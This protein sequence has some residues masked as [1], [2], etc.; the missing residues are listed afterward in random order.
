MIWI[1]KNLETSTQLLLKSYD[2]YIQIW[3]DEKEKTVNYTTEMDTKTTRKLSL[4]S[5]DDIG[6]G[7]IVNEFHE[8][9]SLSNVLWKNKKEGHFLNKHPKIKNY[10]AENEISIKMKLLLMPVSSFIF[11]YSLFKP[12]LLDMVKLDD[13]FISKYG[14]KDKR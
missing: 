13:F 3:W 12:H 2:P 4:L 7:F 1:N 14:N 5:Y 10:I 9:K 11:H 6:E 8:M